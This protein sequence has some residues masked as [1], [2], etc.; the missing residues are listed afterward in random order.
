MEYKVFKKIKL[1]KRHILSVFFTSPLG[2][3]V[4]VIIF[5]GYSSLFGYFYV[6]LHNIDEDYK[7]NYSELRI[8][9]IKSG[10]TNVTFDSL[11][12]TFLFYG[13][14]YWIKIKNYSKD[15]CYIKGIFS[16]DTS[17]TEAFLRNKI[18]KRN[19]SSTHSS[20]MSGW[21]GN[22]IY[23]DKSSWFKVQTYFNSNDSL[24]YLHNLF[25]YSNIS[26]GYYDLYVIQKINYFHIDNEPLKKIIDSVKRIIKYKIPKMIY[27]S[28]TSK[29]LE[30]YTYSYKDIY[31]I[32]GLDIKDTIK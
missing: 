27:F 9:S 8:D 3:T 7:K 29:V 23:P 1:K 17:V 6:R 19:T 25:L 5:T 28:D 15:V 20:L 16:K 10:A 14:T 2:I 32:K 18:I 24:H 21:I 11:N 13:L 30:P 26:G 12:N 31:F 4:L 22:V